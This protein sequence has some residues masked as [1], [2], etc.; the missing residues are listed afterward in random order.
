MRLKRVVDE[1][2]AKADA[3]WQDQVW[4]KSEDDRNIGGDVEWDDSAE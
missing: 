2:K 3:P 1:A 4:S